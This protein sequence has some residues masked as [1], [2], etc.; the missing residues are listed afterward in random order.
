MATSFLLR[1]AASDINPGAEL[2]KLASLI[3]GASS[4]D[5][6]TNTVAGPTAAVQCT[7]TAGGTVLSWFTVPLSAVTVSGTITFNIRARESM[8]QANAGMQVKVERTDRAGTVQST[9]VDSE[10]GTELTTT[11]AAQNWTA[12]STSTD[13]SEGD[14]LKISLF[15]N[16]AGGNMASGHTVTA[17]YDGATAGAAGDSYVTFNE[18]V[19]ELLPPSRS[20]STPGVEFETASLV[21]I[22]IGRAA[23]HRHSYVIPPDL[24][25]TLL[26]PI[27]PVPPGLAGTL[28]QF[29][30]DLASLVGLRRGNVWPWYLRAA[31][32]GEN[33]NMLA[34]NEPPPPSPEV[35]PLFM[36]SRAG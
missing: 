16:D 6:V 31:S 11:D 7:A 3:R 28:A 17:S 27:E 35:K 12:A 25:T 14:R 26:A 2:E 20:G 24:Q 19:L 5:S 1:D 21:G 4:V 33:Q 32:L 10:F 18:T 15:I 30:Y 8:V 29:D 9:V 34:L 13:L 36:M 23:R 22:L